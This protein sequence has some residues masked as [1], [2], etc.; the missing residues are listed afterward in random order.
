MYVVGLLLLVLGIPLLFFALV[1]IAYPVNTMGVSTRKKALPYLL[2]SFWMLTISSCMADRDVAPGTGDTDAEQSASSSSPDERP[3]AADSEPAS[4]PLATWEMDLAFSGKYN[5]TLSYEAGAIVLRM[6][7]DDGSSD[8][9]DLIERPS[10]QPHER[11]FDLERGTDRPEYFTLTDAGVVKYFA[12]D[13]RHV[14]SVNTTFLH[15]DFL[16]VGSDPVARDCVPK[17]LSALSMEVIELYEWLHTFKDDP[18][19]SFY[20]FAQDPGR[21]WMEAARGLHNRSMRTDVLAQSDQLGFLAGEVMQL[22]S[23]YMQVARGRNASDYIQDMER[24]I[25]AG[26]ALATCRAATENS[27]ADP[28]PE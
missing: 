6:A 10:E 11:W 17:Q 1:N 18:D 3:A 20:G 12:W 26:L 2:W 5:N 15:E 4:T 23:E 13:G 25:Q 24:T 21:S 7:F 19:F 27:A 8:V 14:A 28:P 16:A 9:W 22:G